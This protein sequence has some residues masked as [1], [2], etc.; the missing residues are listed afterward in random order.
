MLGQGTHR[1]YI[2]AA[3]WFRAAAE[4][5]FAIAQ[6]DLAYLY[7]TGQGVDRDYR[8]AAKWAGLAAEQ[9]DATAQTDLGYLYE[10]GKGVPLDY[11][12][13]YAWYTLGEA[14]GNADSSRQVKSLSRLMP[15]KQLA[16]AKA[17]VAVVSQSRR[18]N[19]DLSSLGATSF[20]PAH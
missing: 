1:D 13:A 11:V 9:G 7:Y 14:G 20:F 16:E 12:T 8:E 19:E 17:R 5:G 10:Q 2:E 18:T 6:V 15:A 3:K 4:K